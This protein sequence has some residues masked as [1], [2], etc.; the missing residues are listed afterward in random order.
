[1]RH[2]ISIAFFLIIT[3]PT[4]AQQKLKIITTT[5]KELW[6]TSET[7]T[8]ISAQKNSDVIIKSSDHL[9]TIEGFGVCFNEMGW[10]SLNALNVADRKS[11]MK[12][13]FQKNEGLNL[14]VCRMPIGANDFSRDWY[15]YN[16]TDQDFKM[17]NFSISNDLQT[18]VPFI[19]EAKQYAP[20]LKIWASPWSPPSW[21]KWNK[22]YACSMSDGKD[23]RYGNS[24]TTNKQGKEGT[25]MF[26]MEDSYLKAYSLYFKKFIKAYRSEGIKISSV[27]PQNEFNSCQIFPSCTWTASGLSLFI[28]KYLG[29]TMKKQ[30]VEIM[31]G[32]MERPNEA[33]VDSVLKDKLSGQYINGVGF[34]WGGKDA[35]QGIHT[36]YPD[37][38]LY[39]TEQECGDGK[40]EWTF[41]KYAWTLMKHYIN[42][43]ANAY[44]YWNLALEEGGISRWGWHQNSLVSVNKEAKT[45][46]YN[47]DYYVLKH[48]S[49][50]VHPGAKLLKTSGE[51]TNLLAFKNPDN[52]L[53]IIAQ[54]DKSVDEK[55]SINIDGKNLSL[56]LKADSFNTLKME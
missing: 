22:N 35:I 48:V 21:L 54:N 11:I 40:N 16:E 55:I 32:T 42:S 1:M 9:Q 50:F 49:N 39:Q 53:I 15:S 10:L 12:D 51:F 45:F 19:K 4:F 2:L 56:L 5:E 26:I 30:K 33:L 24:L 43:G 47:Y 41:S 52:S 28:G 6:K 7:A 23:K 20:D 14:N 13:L 37:L 18:L 36:R 29:P 46:R 27:M 34:Q 44:M 31:F 17:K 8:W 3:I 38:K 25:N